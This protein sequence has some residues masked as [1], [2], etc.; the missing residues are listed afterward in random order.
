[1]KLTAFMYSVTL[2]AILASVATTAKGSIINITAAFRLFVRV[3]MIFIPEK[4]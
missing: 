3:R 1:M 2:F 4:I